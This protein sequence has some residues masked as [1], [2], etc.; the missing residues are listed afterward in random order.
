MAPA[1][2]W[3]GP[4]HVLTGTPGALW[5]GVDP[6]WAERLYAACPDEPVRALTYSLPL[7]TAL[8]DDLP[9][10]RL[11][12]HARFRAQAA[13]LQALSDGLIQIATLPATHA[14]LTL[15]GPDTLYLGSANFGVQGWLEAGLTL[16]DP[17]AYAWGCAQFDRLWARADRVAPDFPIEHRQ[18]AH[19]D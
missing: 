14:K 18:G 8:P 11:I 1:D 4:V 17:A 16:R 19:D 2:R 10:I 13:R 15:V 12:C 3:R 6:G 9:P 5:L 7:A